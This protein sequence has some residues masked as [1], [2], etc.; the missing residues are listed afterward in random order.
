MCVVCVVCVVFVVFCVFCVCGVRGVR[1][2]CCVCVLCYVVCVCGVRGVCVCVGVV[3]CVLCCVLLVLPTQRG[4]P[5]AGPR[6]LRRTAQN[7]ALFFPL[8]LHFRSF[9]VP[10]GVF[11]WN[12][13]GV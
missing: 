3:F 5:S 8:P 11:S 10:L 7:F 2:V 13:G 9:C 4:P 12:F 1:V 6:P